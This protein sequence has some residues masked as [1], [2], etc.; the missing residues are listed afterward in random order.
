AHVVPIGS[1]K[2][3]IGHL[4]GAAGMAGLIKAVL[5]ISQGLK[6]KSVNYEMPNQNLRAENSP[7]FVNIGNVLW[8]NDGSRP[9]RAAVSSMGFGGTNFHIVLEEYV[10]LNAR[11]RQPV[12]ISLG[13]ETAEEVRD[14]FSYLADTTLPAANDSQDIYKLL[15]DNGKGRRQTIGV[16]FV[17]DTGEALS[18][19]FAAVRDRMADKPS[20]NGGIS[21]WDHEASVADPDK[22][23]I[24]FPGQGSQFVGM[25]LELSEL[26]SEAKEIFG[27][28]DRI[29]KKR[30]GVNLS[31]IIRGHAR[32]GDTEGM[33][34]LRKTEYFQPAVLV[35]SVA[36]F[37]IWRWLGVKPFCAIGHSLGEY[38]ALVAAGVLEFEEALEAVIE[39]G[40]LTAKHSVPGTMAA[41]I[42][43]IKV[44]RNSLK[45][46]EGVYLANMNSE[47]QQVISG[48]HEAIEKA[49]EYFKE[50]RI[51]CVSFPVTGAF[52]SPLMNNVQSL[53][54][55]TLDRLTYS[56]PHFAVYSNV[57]AQ[58]YPADEIGRFA[59]RTLLKQIVAPVHF[60]KQVRLAKEAGAAR[61]L[62]IGP[63]SVLTNMVERDGIQAHVTLSKSSH[64]MR[65]FLETVLSFEHQLNPEKLS[66]LNR[67]LSLGTKSV[68]LSLKDEQIADRKRRSQPDKQL[69]PEILQKRRFISGD[70]RQGDSAE[71]GLVTPAKQRRFDD[72][73]TVIGKLRDPILHALFNSPYFSLFIQNQANIVHDSMVKTILDA[74][75]EHKR[76]T[77]LRTSMKTKDLSPATK[78]HSNVNGVQEISA[79]EARS[80]DFE[81]TLSS[82]TSSTNIGFLLRQVKEAKGSLAKKAEVADKAVRL[83]IEENK[84]SYNRIVMGGHGP[85][86]LVMDM[87]TSAT[88]QCD[89]WITNHYLGL[90]RHPD[91]MRSSADAA[92]RYGTGCGTSAVAGGVIDIHHDLTQE[93]A[94]LLGKDNAILFSTGFTANFGFLSSIVSRHDTVI[95][96]EECH[97][98]MIEGILHSG[99]TYRI[100]RHNDVN[101]LRTKLE[102]TKKDTKSANVF[103]IIE[104]VYSL[105]GEEAPVKDICGLKS[106]YK[107][108]LFVDEAHSFG[109]Y[110][111]NGAG[112]CAKEGVLESVDFV[113]STLS[114]A[115]A[116][117]GGFVAC[118]SSYCEFVRGT[119]RA[120]MFQATLPPADAAA[121]LASLRLLTKDPSYRKILWANTAYLRK[122]LLDQ[123]FDLG[124]SVSPIVPVYVPDYDKLTSLCT[125]LF[126]NGVYSTVIGFPGVPLDKGRL[127]FIVTANHEATGIDRTVKKL[128]EH[129]KR[130]TII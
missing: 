39:R 65:R 117:L 37:E 59:K 70:G 66:K 40:R 8:E 56:P 108:F 62:E 71:P 112:L 99:A 26:F 115:T 104:S 50:K 114:K 6:P 120:Y 90:N 19:Q 76:S 23:C 25:G 61:F 68:V 33:G 81:K 64:G 58:I 9:R 20:D 16:S 14:R 12:I 127:R 113:M 128:T 67:R 11:K 48:S 10:P 31:T 49:K 36:C 95:F 123:G 118:D 69:M 80:F 75:R 97:A 116:S 100:F 124:R 2:A 107:F 15:S 45:E 119:A 46:L 54:S 105:S 78:D 86:A 72:V 52:H 38:S 51:A 1:V 27:K 103:V 57:G 96:D 88:Q 73:M 87:D 121:A 109:L 83:S 42:A 55:P 60:V 18:P 98:S 92:L 126:H 30:W 125:A 17:V 89:I 3:Q 35:V 122:C 63:G 77:T 4:L 7:L 32:I 84:F 74:F 130:L 24:M 82:L 28:A 85:T 44:V 91:V 53:F 22:L 94:S 13:G 110:G 29:T 41:V 106:E 102:E 21:W 5:C 111:D 34:L 93:I 101:H 43:D 129:A 47:Q 79:N